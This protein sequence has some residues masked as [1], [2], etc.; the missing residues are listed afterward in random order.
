MK[1]TAGISIDS[2]EFFL[3]KFIFANPAHVP[4]SVRRIERKEQGDLVKK[5]MDTLKAETPKDIRGTCVVN[6]AQNTSAERL[7]EGLRNEGL[8]VVD[9]Q[10]WTQQKLGQKEPKEAVL[11]V[12]GRPQ[13]GVEPIEIDISS[14]TDNVV[15]FC[16]M[17]QNPTH[18][19]SIDFVSRQSGQHIKN[20]AVVEEGVVHIVPT[21][22]ETQRQKAIRDAASVL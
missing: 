16:H 1:S 18:V 22:D 5:L 19:H 15:W 14:L 21:E 4:D 7:F 9:V 8:V 3:T 11:L 13:D 12:W 17:W 10:N 2:G 6:N 20:Y